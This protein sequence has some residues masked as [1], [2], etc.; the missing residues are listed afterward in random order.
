MEAFEQVRTAAIQLHNDVVAAGASSL[1]PESLL[2]GAIKRLDLELFS[3]PSGDPALKGARAIF[4]E[5]SGTI[6]CEETDDPGD[7][8]ELVTHE[9]AHTVLH[10][11][12]A[13]CM[14]TD[15]DASQT[16]ESAPVGL[17]RVEDYGVRE[18]RE[19]Q[20]NVFARE[21]LLP[22]RHA[23]HLF[24]KEGL[25]AKQITVKTGLSINLVRQQLFDALLLPFPK[26]REATP[27]ASPMRRDESQER[28]AKHRGRA[29][30]LQAGPGTGKTRTL[31]KAVVTLLSECV[32]PSSILILTFSNRAAG[33]L[34]ER[35][36]KE[37]QADASQIWIGTFHAFGLDLLRRFHDRLGLPAEPRLFDRSD[38]IEVLE[39]I[40]PTLP[41][42]HY[43]NL[44]DPVIVLREMITAISRAKDE[45]TGPDEYRRL[46]EAMLDSAS[47]EDGKVAAEKCL[48]VSQIYQLYE[49]AL[50]THESVDFGDL[51]M[52]P[53]LLLESDEVVRTSVQF[54]HR[55]IFVDEYQDVNRASARLVKAIVGDG[56]RLWVV[57]DARQSIYRFRGASST[58]MAMFE[59]DYPGAKADSLAVSY[60]SS[61]EI[62][63]T[64]EVIAPNMG[65]SDGML[66][67]SLESD[68]GPT[69]QRP[70]IRRYD[71][72]EDEE[73]GIAA[74]IRELESQGIA[75][76]DQA[77]LCRTHQRLNDIAGALEV[78]GIPVLHL[79]SLFEREEIRDILSLLNLAVDSFGD[80][81]VRVGAMPRYGLSLQDVYLATRHYRQ[82]PSVSLTDLANTPDLSESGKIG[83]KRLAQDLDGIVNKT[84]WEFLSTYLL[85]RSD[86]LRD[87]AGHESVSN[88]MRGIALWQFLNFARSTSAVGKGHPI[89]RVLD[90]IRQ[91][92]LFAEERD[93][94]QVP[95]V[96][97]RIDAVRLMTVHGSKG[98]EFEAVHIPTLTTG[99]FPSS[100]R[101]QRCPP[102]AGMIA[103]SAISVAEHSRQSH[104]YEEEC[105]FFV[106]VS[107]ARSRLLLHLPAETST[108]R[109]RTPSRFLSWIDTPLIVEIASP[110]IMPEPPDCPKAARLEIEWAEGVSL[111]DHSIQ[112]YHSCPLRF[113][114]THVLGLAGA[115]KST[116]FS[117]THDCIYGFVE[118]LTAERRAGEVSVEQA[119]QSFDSIWEERGPTEHGYAAEYRR[120][121][122][123]LIQTLIQFGVSVS[124]RDVEALMIEFI[125]GNVVIEP[126]ELIERPDGSMTLRK[127]RTGKQRKDE[128]DRLEHALYQLA[129]E[130]AYGAQCTVEVLHL[131]DG[132]STAVELTGPKL[133]F[134]RDKIM[135]MVASIG[136]GH[137]PASP[138][139]FSCPRC[140]HFFHCPS[141]PVGPLSLAGDST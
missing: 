30:Q 69:Q 129:G 18:R 26:P 140:P 137:F 32:H 119:E 106:A 125:E 8:A 138:D 22:K 92:V 42:N 4:D 35:I 118:W 49:E 62:V 25:G 29:F 47:D 56:K 112:S 50:R 107:R 37:V 46:S 75:L 10:A 7:K 136:N 11:G 104:E 23:R 17:Q 14:R 117:R 121:A 21:F 135:G 114:Y 86:V 109:N 123:T 130:A 20:A 88:A 58:N 91:L 2:S 24:L 9:I 70:E 113:F 100:Y 79:G 61:L 132:T 126:N 108:G 54:R 99:N 6:C 60:R 116:A 5:Q 63:K 97:L 45:L 90:R 64:I 128:Q 41:L 33:E 141:V 51:V 34:T 16:E 83:V 15:I 98:L 95:P 84:A 52:K 55:H 76:R 28:A 81:L 39:E 68:T 66:P 43:R 1:S 124:F 80:S 31:V 40:L 89:R 67:L 111:T 3:L 87:I 12:A 53:A 59:Q 44:W 115:K 139:Q 127:I 82:S 19:L 122:S 27:A 85:D 101:G 94:R 78:R 71:G 36:S 105:L 93:L 72:P 134:R 57:G 38:A 74:S 120:L 13:S 103:K 102:P 110:P 65:A 96:A 131:T 77:V 48:E 133:K 73:A